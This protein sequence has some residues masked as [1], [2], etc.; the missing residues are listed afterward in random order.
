M[1]QATGGDEGRPKLQLVNLMIAMVFPEVSKALKLEIFDRE[2]MLFFA[3]VVRKAVAH[4]RETRTKR[5]DM[6]DLVLEALEASEKE[7]REVEDDQ[8]E[9]DAQI[10]SS[11]YKI[12]RDEIEL[13][14]ISN[15]II[16]FFAG[17]DTSSSALSMTLAFLSL[18]PDVQEKLYQEI[19]DA[20]DAQGATAVLD[21]QVVQA[22][23]YLDMVFNETLRFYF[24]ATLERVCSKDYLLPGT[25]FVVPEG[26]LVQIPSS[27]LHHD[28]RYY[29]DPDNFNPDENF[30]EESRAKRSPYAFL[31]FGQGP[32]NCM[33]MR[34]ALLM[35]K[36]CLV[37]IV[38][39]FRLSPGP[40]MPKEFIMSAA[41]FNGMP[42]GGVWCK[43]EKR[44]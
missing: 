9:K 15:A 19:C 43:V 36:K 24:T 4:R 2:S 17:F 28:A 26:A 8:F 7:P 25:S 33:G 23:P 16:L 31:S 37:E 34:F 38:T 20:R 12:E 1:L 5:G 27:A 42:K 32:R 6:I 21:Y 3:E 14:L 10:D 35:A 18:H 13:L 44:E 39:N 30:S 40:N 41:T 29:P 11:E 22:L